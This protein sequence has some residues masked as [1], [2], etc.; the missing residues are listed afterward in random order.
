[1]PD[2]IE[3]P[4]LKFGVLCGQKVREQGLFGSIR[5]VELIVEIALHDEVELQPATPA[6][7]A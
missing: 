6:L 2:A 7:P 4:G 5:S 3:Y 1:M